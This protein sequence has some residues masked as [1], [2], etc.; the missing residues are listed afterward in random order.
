MNPVFRKHIEEA[1]R[2]N[3]I[4][5]D[6]VSDWDSLLEIHELAESVMQADD[7]GDSGIL[8]ASTEIGGVLFYRMTIGSGEWLAKVSP[9]FADNSRMEILAWAYAMAGA[10]NP[11]ENLWP[12]ADNKAKLSAKLKEFSRHIGATPNELVHGLRVFV[13]QE[14][15]K[16][17][18]GDGQFSADES[19][20]YGFGALIDMLLHEYGGTP[21]QWIWNTPRVTLMELIKKMAQRKRMESADG[22]SDPN[23]PRVIASHR[24]IIRLRKMV[25]DKKAKV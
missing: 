6:P 24:L 17:M 25:D 20:K 4:K 15:P 3:G 7:H 16:I 5:F 12:F 10:R 23:D 14:Q 2:I 8:N 1:Q 22:K 18:P 21:E 19:P 13:E 9:W 11:I